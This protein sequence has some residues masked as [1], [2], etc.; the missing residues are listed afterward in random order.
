M[1]KYGWLGQ[2]WTIEIDK[3]T[4]HLIIFFGIKTKNK[5]F[6]VQ[7]PSDK[8]KKK[9]FFSPN[10]THD[11]LKAVMACT[12]H[13]NAKKNLYIYHIEIIFFYIINAVE[14]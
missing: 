13:A 1:S 7:K 12:K 10:S 14:Q 3:N 4:S 9:L 8:Q 6:S 11:S 2:L 5:Q